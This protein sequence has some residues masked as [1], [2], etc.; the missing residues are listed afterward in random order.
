MRRNVVLCVCERAS[1]HVC[2]V[3]SVSAP[4][5]LLCFSHILT[6]RE[7]P[8][9]IFEAPLFPHPQT[10]PS[11]KLEFCNSHPDSAIIRPG[12]DKGALN[13]KGSK[14]LEEE[15]SSFFN[16]PP[17]LNCTNGKNSL[18]KGR[19]IL[20]GFTRKKNKRTEK[21]VATI[22]HKFRSLQ[23]KTSSS[24]GKFCV[25][26]CVCVCLFGGDGWMPGKVT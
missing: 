11:L 10:P 8:R 5:F 19:T 14:R 21:E 26:E 12:R 22:F 4:L 7:A 9:S 13:C 2:V 20:N 17:L 23:A 1:L 3:C 18:P 25:T 6:F 15:A 16:A 24:Q